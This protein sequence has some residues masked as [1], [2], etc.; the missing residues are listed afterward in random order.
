M[1]FELS[2]PLG[3]R[4]AIK[5]MAVTIAIPPTIPK[6]I[7]NFLFDEVEAWVEAFPCL[8]S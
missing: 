1:T 8:K 5:T 7:N 2:L 4:T 6:D 3:I